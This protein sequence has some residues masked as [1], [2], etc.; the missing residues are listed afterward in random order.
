M[1]NLILIIV[2]A[3]YQSVSFAITYDCKVFLTIPNFPG[4]H[5][6]TGQVKA[7]VN[8]N[9]TRLNFG[10][11]VYVYSIHMGY[12][13]KFLKG[14]GERDWRATGRIIQDYNIDFKDINKDPTADPIGIRNFFMFQTN[15]DSIFQ[16][17]SGVNYF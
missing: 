5:G 13:T 4:F 3:M 7:N 10:S 1:K 6:P 17:I 2:L 16:C 11:E 8:A 15:G 12:W 14:N 9:K